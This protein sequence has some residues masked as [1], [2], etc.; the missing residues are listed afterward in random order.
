MRFRDRRDAGE[1]LGARLVDEGL[2]RP[3]VL[4]LPRGGVPVA[5]EVARALGAPLEVFVVRKLGVPWHPEL[6]V[7][8]LAEG[9]EP[10]VHEASL[11]ELGLTR[12]QLEPIIERERAELAR[13]V[14]RYRGG[15]ALPELRDR[16]VVVVDDGL[17][18][19]VSAQAALLALR[20]LGPRRL[21]LA[22]PVCAP[23][24]AQRLVAEGCADD[25]VSLQ[26]PAHFYAVG[27][28][29]ERFDQ[30]SDDEVLALLADAR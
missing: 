22:V 15:R 20:A 14:K 18:T 9:G 13:R 3:L 17:A 7:G 19:G 25:V 30:T 23:D 28:W 10:L 24:T 1:R 27:A 6:G 29:Y 11:R 16:D 21:I 4:A 8:A 12:D 26:A 2:T 5:A